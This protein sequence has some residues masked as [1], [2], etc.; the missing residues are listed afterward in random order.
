[1]FVVATPLV[2]C[3]PGTGLSVLLAVAISLLL[4][5][6]VCQSGTGLCVLLAVAIPLLLSLLFY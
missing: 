1:L 4:S 5:L 2:V 3:Q 6:L